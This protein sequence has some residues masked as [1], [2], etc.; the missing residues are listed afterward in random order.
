VEYH[1][2]PES[3]P[4][5][6]TAFYGL[7]E[8][9]FSL[10]PDPRFLYLAESHREAF[11]HLLYGIEQGEG[12]I[13]ITG[14]VGTGKT[15]LCRSLLERLG[16]ETEIAFLFN[17]S[18]SP[19]EL[20]QA[21]AAELGLP[22]S[23]A[24]RRALHDRLN[25]HLLE[26]KRQGRRVL[27]IVDE[28][29]NLSPGTLEQ[30][31]LLSNL[32]TS[33]EKLIQIL[34]L[35]QPEL[36]AKLDSP[37]LRQLRQRIGVRWCLGPLGPRETRAYVRHRVRVAADSERE[38]F[39]EGALRE[40][41]RRSRGIP[42]LV[43]VLC[44]RSLLAGYARREGRIDAAQVR[45]VAREIPDTRGR[46][47]RRAAAPRRRGSRRALRVAAALV[48]FAAAAIAGAR[49]D[50][51]RALVRGRLAGGASA[52]VS[53]PAPGPAP[54]RASARRPAAREAGAPGAG[55][56][57]SPSAAPA[58][59]VSAAAS[60]PASE[61]G[62]ARLPGAEDA[63]L[64]GT[65]LDGRESGDVLGG[66]VD[67]V[68][69]SFQLEPGER[70]LASEAEAR[71]VLSSA[72]LTVLELEGVG[73]E[74]L[75]SLNHPA[76][77]ALRSASGAIR[78]VALLGLEGDLATVQGV[79]D[80]GP[81]SVPLEE[82]ASR[83]EGDAWV[84]WRDYAP[85]PDVIAPGADTESIRW[86]QSALGELGFYPGPPTGAWDGSTDLAVRTLQAQRQ[87]RPDGAVGPRTRMVLYDLLDA[88]EVPRLVASEGSG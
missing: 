13:A 43:N 8:K 3:D 88:Y 50:D 41:H 65:L 31:R 7:R 71:R 36:D 34:L 6:Y 46:W 45:R 5:M 52:A 73:F 56:A 78:R 68:L 21:I 33:S 11:A 20:L 48:L 84:V 17:P 60:L 29:Q 14:E 44:D 47:R 9:P 58:S 80:R 12:F 49:Y 66:S 19:L 37:E 26:R 83:W 54:D 23:G 51:L 42:R 22:T 40:V 35:G 64:L 82:M 77:L 18:R 2:G 85:V 27:L 87:L 39:T 32:E 81:L 24:G 59:P 70:D 15:T 25:H 38:L 30:I 28:A 69:R 76:L 10:S 1:S 72:G 63:G 67:T 4:A 55:E 57:P 74:V 53:A 86:L 75:R 16:S 62:A 61:P 79:T